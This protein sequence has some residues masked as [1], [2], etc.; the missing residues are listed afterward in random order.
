MKY[1]FM[2]KYLFCLL[3]CCTGFVSVFAQTKSQT[4]IAPFKIRLVNGEGYTYNQLIKDKAA[5][6][7]YFSPTCD[8]CIDF[9]KAMLKRKKELKDKQIV[10]ISYE[11]LKEIK[12]F[13]DLYKLS[14][15]PNIK[16]GSEGYTF[17]VQKY[18]GIQRF[19]FVAEYNKGGKLVKVISSQ[20]KPE[21][22]AAQL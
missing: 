11:Q 14:S 16:I 6:L 8:H 4:A 13:D 20:L 2:Y 7:I 3:F 12:K 21:E 19:P 18:Y 22:M 9:T 15:Q 1:L 10:M 17:V 5:I